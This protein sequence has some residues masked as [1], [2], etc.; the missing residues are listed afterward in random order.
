MPKMFRWSHRKFGD[1]RSRRGGCMTEV[2][3]RAL[4]SLH[5]K[6]GAEF[7][8]S[9]ALRPRLR[10][11]QTQAISPLESGAPGGPRTLRPTDSKSCDAA[12]Q[13][14]LAVAHSCPKCLCGAALKHSGQCSLLLTG[15]REIE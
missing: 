15:D 14:K 10:K 3:P 5:R 6:N 13:A 12:R 9:T 7:V 8:C 2:Y 4:R 1:C 11:R